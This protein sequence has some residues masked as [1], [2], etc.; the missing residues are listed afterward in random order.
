MTMIE[1]NPAAVTS[2][3]TIFAGRSIWSRLVCC[4]ASTI[5]VT[6]AE[7]WIVLPCTSG[8][9]VGPA[10]LLQLVTDD[11]FFAWLKPMTSLIVEIDEMARVDFDAADARAVATRV[12]QLFGSGSGDA[13]S[14][15]YLQLLQ[16]EP[17][18][19]LVC[20]ILPL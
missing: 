18:N 13:F 12:E 1:L 7:R 16:R 8:T 6:A 9:T 2:G 17:V 19:G 4:S 10:Q 3:R 5:A 11:P 20:S 15:R 14:E